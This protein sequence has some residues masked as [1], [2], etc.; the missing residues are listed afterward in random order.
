LDP[1]GSTEQA[2]GAVAGAHTTSA[3]LWVWTAGEPQRAVPGPGAD[4][5]PGG[6][7][8]HRTGASGATEPGEQRRRDRLESGRAAVVAACGGKCGSDRVRD[9]VGAW[10]RAVEGKFGCRLRGVSGA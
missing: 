5:E 9:W 2:D 10:L 4:G 8:L 1:G 3:G 7:D 6:S